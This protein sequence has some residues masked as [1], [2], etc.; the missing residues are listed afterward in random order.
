[1]CI[2]TE[3]GGFGDRSDPGV[4]GVLDDILTDFDREVDKTSINCGVHIFEKMISGMYL[5]EIVRLVLVELT[6][7]NL[8]F[9][10]KLPTD[11]G[12]KDKFETKHMSFIEGARSAQEVIGTIQDLLQV[13]CSEADAR[14]VRLVCDTISTRS[15][16]LC[17]AALA[18]IADRI[19]SDKDNLKTAVGVDGTVYKKHPNFRHKL[20]DAV[21]FL[22]PKCDLKFY[23]SEDGSGKGAA[24]VTAVAQRQPPSRLSDSN[25]EDEDR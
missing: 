14:V 16:N 19:R 18:A 4:P 11:L 25:G 20:E 1:M 6:N 3:W 5:G 24:M 13:E 9:E 8:L 2:N 12:T 7:K 21:T 10:G 23:I 17:G 15:A 22:A